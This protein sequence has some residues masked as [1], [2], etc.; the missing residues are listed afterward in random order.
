MAGVPQLQKA[1][2]EVETGARIECMFNPAKFSFSQANRWESDQIPGKATPTMRYAGGEGGSFALSLVFDTTADGT[3]VT[4]Y[5]NKL[6]KLMDVD[7]TLPGYDATRS[8]GRPPWVKFHWGTSLHSFKAVVK[9]IDVGFTYFSSEGLPLRANVEM[10]LEQYE[11]DANWGPQNPTSG[12]PTPEPHPPGRGRRH[13]RPHLGPLLRRSDPVAGDR[14]RQRSRRSARPPARTTSRHPRAGWE[15]DMPPSTTLLVF[16]PKILVDGAEIPQER[17]DDIIDLRVSQSVSVPSQL[18]LRL[19]DPEFQLIDGDSVRH[20][21]ADRSRASR[22]PPGT[23][24]TVFKGEIVSVGTDQNAERADACELVAHRPRPCPPPRPTTTRIRTFQNQSYSDV[25]STIAGEEGLAVSTDV[26][27]P[28]FDYLIQTTTNYAFL[29][30]IAFRTG[31]Q[32]TI[33]DGKLE[34]NARQ[35]SPPVVVEYGSDLRRIKARYSTANETTNVTVRSWDPRS[36]AV[37]TG[38]A[39]LTSVRNNRANTGTAPLGSAGRADGSP[40]A[41]SLQTAALIAGSTDEAKQLADCPRRPARHRRPQRSRRVPRQPGHHGR[42]NGRDHERRNQAERHVL[43]HIG[44]AHLRTR[45]RHDDDVHDRRARAARRSSTCS[46]AATTTSRRSAASG[47][48]SG[49]SPTTRI[50]T[51]SAGCGSSSRR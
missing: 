29:N 11:P 21:Q 22:A 7:T 25:L 31:T 48:R 6:L 43:R 41:G 20:R 10:R 12:T 35:S 36:K 51:A 30:E 46:A 24:L 49:S 50:P 1:Y 33:D 4:G 27:K 14:H 32:W 17:Y 15:P 38:R 23:W 26:T 39:A 18:T 13:A 45:R 2:L 42:R 8:N 34:V 16:V 28:R 3:A 44:R 9:S 19:S 37:V 5:T 47:S 40:F